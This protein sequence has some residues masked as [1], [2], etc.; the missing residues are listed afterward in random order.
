[1]RTDP[2]EKPYPCAQCKN[3]FTCDEHLEQHLGN[4]AGEK[5]FAC[6][7]CIMKLFYTPTH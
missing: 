5:L 1:M 2:G 4:H 3:I 6:I 7:Q